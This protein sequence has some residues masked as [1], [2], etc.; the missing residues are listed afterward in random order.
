MATADRRRSDG[1]MAEP[2]LSE[3]RIMSFNFP[4]KGWALCNGQLLPINQNQALFS[5]LGTTYG[6]D[7][8]VDLRTAE[9]PGTRAHPHRQR[10]HARRDGRRAEPH[11]V[12]RRAARCTRTP[13][14]AAN[15]AAARPPPADTAYLG[16]AGEH[17]PRRHATWWRWRR[18]RSR[19]SV[20]ASRTRTCSRSWCSASAS[21]CRG[22]SP[23]RTR[24][25]R[26]WH[27]RTSE[28]FGC[29]AATSRRRAGCSATAS[30]CRS[31]RTRRSSS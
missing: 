16:A 4:P 9:S 5:L 28:R 27:S 13:L 8:R 29:S 30:S 20:A 23:R 22:S 31:P 1:C 12:H 24:R 2:F 14:R 26:R 3:I 15:S 19:T 21:P 7:G 11:A 10:P 25:S 17:L 18:A 6:G